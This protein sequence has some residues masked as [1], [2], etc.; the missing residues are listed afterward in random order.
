MAANNDLGS[1]SYSLNVDISQLPDTIRD[2][3]RQLSGISTV[4]DISTRVDSDQLI[5]AIKQALTAEDF[6]LKVALDDSFKGV[7]SDLDA[8]MKQVTEGDGDGEV[9]LGYIDSLI[10]KLKELEAQYRSLPEGA[11]ASGL[12]QEFKAIQSELDGAGKNL[13]AAFNK[14]WEEV[15]QMSENTIGDI[16]NKI[17]SLGQYKLSIPVAN[18]DEV[19]SAERLISNL[20]SD[21]KSLTSISVAR[22]FADVMGMDTATLNQISE[23]LKEI[24]KLRGDIDAGTPKGMS[25]INALN[26]S[27]ADLL[28]LQKQRLGVVKQINAS[29]ADQTKLVQ[30]LTSFTLTYFSASAVKQF[31]ERVRETTGEF[32]KQRIAL[33]AI[34]QS[35]EDANRLFSQVVDLGLKSPFSIMELNGYVRQLSAFQIETEQLYDTTK[36]LA[37]ISAGLNVDMGRLI[38]AYGQVR[39]AEYLRGQEVRQFTEAGIPIIGKLAAQFAKLEGRAVSVAEVFDRIS[40]REVTFENVRDALWEMTDAGGIFFNMQ[41]QLADSLAAK[42]KNLQDVLDVMYNSIG[43]EYSDD[44]K[45]IIELITQL[46][47]RWR[48]VLDVMQGMLVVYGAYK[49]ALLVTTAAQKIN[50]AVLREA[51]LL[52]QQN[53][54]ANIAMGKSALV[55][56]AQTTVL[57]A[58]LTRMDKATKSNKIALILAGI[59]AIGF[60]IHE[61]VTHMNEWED[62]IKGIREEGD[63]LTASIENEQAKI[64]RLFGSLDSL[65]EGTKEYEEQKQAIIDQYGGYLK[66]LG[67]EIE[68]LGNVEAA[69]KAISSAAKQSAID[70]AI[71]AKTEDLDNVKRDADAKAIGEL[72][73]AIAES[74]MFRSSRNE[75]REEA[76][77]QTI[78]TELRTNKELSDET[79]KLV[80]S[81]VK[82]ESYG[83]GGTIAMNAVQFRVDDM[84]EIA[85]QYQK[86]VDEIESVM[87]IQR[88]D[89]MKLEYDQLKTHLDAVTK[90]YEEAEGTNKE[91]AIKALKDGKVIMMSWYELL[92]EKRRVE[93]ALLVKQP[94]ADLNLGEEYTKAKDAYEKAKAL[95]ATIKAN[96]KDYSPKDLEK[97]EKDLERA[98][99]TFKKLGGELD[100]KGGAESK[101]DPVIEKYKERI[102]LIKKANAAYK[103]NLNY[104]S[105]ENAKEQTLS[106]YGEQLKALGLSFEEV[107]DSASYFNSVLSGLSGDPKRL[108]EVRKWV[109]GEQEK[110]AQEAQKQIWGDLDKQIEEYKKAYE[111]FEK[112]R[113]PLGDDFARKFVE[114]TYEG[115]NLA[116]DNF[117]SYFQKLVESNADASAKMGRDLKNKYAKEVKETL[118]SLLNEFQTTEDKIAAIQA[119][120]KIHLD[121]LASAKDSMPPDRYNRMVDLI[122]ERMAN[123][124]AALTEGLL[125]MTDTY[126][127]LFS[128]VSDLSEKEMTRLVD[129]F[130]KALQDAEK[131]GK[132][133]DGLF[134][135]SL[136][137]EEFTAT[138]K[139]MASF[140]K[141]LNKQ[142]A[143]LRKRNPFKTLH[144]SIKEI[145]DNALLKGKLS[146]ELSLLKTERDKAD[147]AKDVDKLNKKIEETEEKLRDLD[148]QNATTWSEM[149]KQIDAVTSQVSG[150][151]NSFISLFDSLGASEDTTATL[152]G[153]VGIVGGLGDTASSVARIASGDVIGGLTQGVKG[154]AEVIS[155]ITSLSDRKHEKQIRRLQEAIDASK[156]A[157]EQ[158]GRAAIRAFGDAEYAARK[159]QI[160]QLKAQQ[161]LIKKQIQEEYDKKKT[162]HDKIKQWEEELRKIGIQIEDGL[163]SIL[164]DILGGNVKSMLDSLSQSLFDAFANGEDAAKAWGEKVKDVIGDVIRSILKQ[165]LIDATLG[166][167]VQRWVDKWVDEDGNFTMSMEAMARDAANLGDWL[168]AR[169]ADLAERIE[170]LPDSVKKYL[171]GDAEG[172][173]SGLSKGIQGLTENTAQIL[174]AYLNTIRD[175]V[176]SIMVVQENQLS[177]L[178]SSQLIQSQILTEVATTSS[179]AV[180]MDK[181]LRSVIAQSNGDNGAGI[182][183][184]IK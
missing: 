161:E 85:Q 103:E 76:I 128:G 94:V 22:N 146:E 132:K 52:R 141:T 86:G 2:V 112:V 25:Q 74:E 47:S 88:N 37:D 109:S 36:R 45:G 43:S 8:A 104:W 124:I 134:H 28:G 50:N 64:D 57:N 38:L 176:I 4:A 53:A 98:S 59:A 172:G 164:E 60:A 169:G 99:S 120:Y 7:L 80:D 168:E 18:K 14:S 171:M 125:E 66:D 148:A 72:R 111:L 122:K 68:Q 16:K 162:N 140:I 44:M 131:A 116:S 115:V 55:A 33:T 23:K 167:V 130:K 79:Q 127:R 71:A 9:Q 58:A 170:V 1:L 19:E 136:D 135:I 183:V 182:R 178:Q 108:K 174:E 13:S 35:R 54:A 156:I 89:Y 40:N 181:A 142:E 163:T 154:V 97:A 83:A 12:I 138:E 27:E 165:R 180:S 96:R 149:A 107:A 160:A 65:T 166:T 118:T 151:A 158:L 155:S 102:D 81:L 106:V 152:N 42:W 82:V 144:D 49:T 78:V 70:R 17:K 93:E 179:A 157:Y 67:L 15:S 63:K 117:E 30:R 62:A 139:R 147:N 48:E 41:E 145:Q 129:K 3:E 61:V 32:E 34:L 29:Y 90:A 159:A 91:I 121:N 73:K 137:G 24:R 184:Y 173:L 77:A 123:E 143:D 100:K 150:L 177:V 119:E 11:D 51:V 10:A 105:E 26:K 21:V 87:G 175:V 113:V 5:G 6:K 84:K 39:A 101:K 92:G 75:R 46:A 20:K 56:A 126:Q 95:V 69:Y 110:V 153:I 31:A 114:Q 133:E